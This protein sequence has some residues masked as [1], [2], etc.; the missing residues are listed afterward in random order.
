VFASGLNHPTGITVDS[1]GNVYD[2]VYGNGVI[3]KYGPGGGTGTVFASPGGTLQD[4]FYY[5]P[6]APTTATP[7]PGA[8]A[9]AAGLITMGGVLY[10]RRKK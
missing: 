4:V 10:R 2:A 7:E 8:V 1:Q 6:M 3:E 9:L 5:D